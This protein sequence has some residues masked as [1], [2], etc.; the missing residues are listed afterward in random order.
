MTPHYWTTGVL[1]VATPRGSRFVAVSYVGEGYPHTVRRMPP[2]ELVRFTSR[3]RI[4]A[5]AASDEARARTIHH[6]LWHDGS[7]WWLARENA[8]G[9]IADHNRYRCSEGRIPR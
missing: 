7:E 3:P 6:N 4:H 8:R 9:L 5:G 2:P 1:E